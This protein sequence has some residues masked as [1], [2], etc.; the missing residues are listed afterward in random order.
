MYCPNFRYEVMQTFGKWMKWWKKVK[1]SHCNLLCFPYTF[2]SNGI[3]RLGVCVVKPRCE[4][5]PWLGF[6]KYKCHFTSHNIKNCDSN[7][8]L[9]Q[10]VLVCTCK[11]QRMVPG[12]SIKRNAG[13]I[14]GQLK[15]TFRFQRHSRVRQ[16]LLRS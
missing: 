7:T 2:S 15:I 14:Y 11:E 9:A 6:G 4:R 3:E 5:S 1:S 16:F 12:V 10:Y 8:Y 13:N